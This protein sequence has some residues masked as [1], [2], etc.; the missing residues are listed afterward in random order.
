MRA[1][2]DVVSNVTEARD[3]IDNRRNPMGMLARRDDFSKAA[4]N[5]RGNGAS[6][7]KPGSKKKTSILEMIRAANN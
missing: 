3:W 4:D 7:K 6:K 2:L 1:A 5:I